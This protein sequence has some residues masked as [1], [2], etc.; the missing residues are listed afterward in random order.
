V[1]RA[2]RAAYDADAALADLARSLAVPGLHARIVSYAHPT[3]IRST[4]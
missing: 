4:A 3:P 2:T 1:L